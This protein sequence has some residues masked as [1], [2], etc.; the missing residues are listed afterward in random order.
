MDVIYRNI[1]IAF[2]AVIVIIILYVIVQE[3]SNEYKRNDI[4][5]ENIGGGEDISL[6]NGIFILPFED[7]QRDNREY[8]LTNG[9][10]QSD[11]ESVFLA[12]AYPLVGGSGDGFFVWVQHQD[13]REAEVVLTYFAG[14]VYFDENR[15]SFVSDTMWNAGGDIDPGRISLSDGMVEVSFIREGVLETNTIPLDFF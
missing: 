8:T 5:K 6:Q 13:I 12:E 14:S 2:I 3:K 10:Y 4:Q 15:G 11:S 9:I 7:D 1:Y